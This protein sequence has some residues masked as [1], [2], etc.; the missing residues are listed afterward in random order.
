MNN[1][2]KWSL[3]GILK[4]LSNNV[5]FTSENLDDIVAVLKKQLEIGP[6]TAIFSRQRKIRLQK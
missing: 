5:D 2:S 1:Y 4:Y 3:L 6:K